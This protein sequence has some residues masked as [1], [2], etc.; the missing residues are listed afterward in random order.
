MND[1]PQPL[2]TPKR[3]AVVAVMVLLVIA[4]IFFARRRGGAG[5][6]EFITATVERGAI[7]KVVNATGTVQALLT[8]QVGVQ[9]TGQVQA[10]YADYNSVVRQGQL[11]A[12]ID[13]RR[14]QADVSGAEANLLAAQARVKSIEA[15]LNSQFANQSSAVANV[16]TAR[17]AR[18]NAAVQ[19]AR[20]EE[21]RRQGISS[22]NEYDNARATR[23]SSEAR[24]TQARAQAEQAAAQIGAGRAQ[25]EQAKAQ[26]AQAQAA[27]NQSRVNLEYT[28]IR[29]PVDG[30][31]IA[32]NVDVGQ[33][34]AASLQAPT[35]FLIAGDLSQMQLQ[36]SVDEADIGSVTISGGSGDSAEQVRFTVDAFPNRSFLGRISE[37][38]LEPLAVQNVV[39][40]SVIVNVD[41]PRLE[42]KPG[43][44][45][46]LTFT[47]AE[48]DGV[49]R[50]P[51]AAL[52]YT[53]PGQL[54]AE[55]PDPLAMQSLDE[56]EGSAEMSA[57]GAAATPPAVAVKNPQARELAPGQLWKPGEKIQFPAPQTDRTQPARVWVLNAQKQPESRQVELGIT[58]GAATEIASGELQEGDV[59][60]I[61]DSSQAAA[62]RG[63]IF[64]GGGPPGR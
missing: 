34:V 24:F 57:S 53:P 13:S 63:G 22:Q 51:N 3:I 2:L 64:G 48:K 44:T 28:D 31:V 5:A 60:V 50:L 47:V 56:R 36:A 9:V 43:M 10:L 12:K 45:A 11:L 19:F 14:Y 20:A 8:V 49:L 18:D 1:S 37:I 35:L 59:V 32:R 62:P 26:V 38:R 46:N 15:E 61:G 27:L 7:R 21:L 6:A 54:A 55:L 40:Y 41:N 4:G 52:R 42:L 29:S 30:V 39:T 33:T 58:D 23:D 17:V 16:E 25:V